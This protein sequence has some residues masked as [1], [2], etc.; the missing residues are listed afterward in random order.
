VEGH[1]AGAGNALARSF[2]APWRKARPVLLPDQVIEGAL[3]GHFESPGNLV[4]R[5]ARG[6][7]DPA[8]KAVVRSM[9]M[10][11]MNRWLPQP[12]RTA[13]RVSASEATIGAATLAVDSKLLEDVD[14]DGRCRHRDRGEA[15]AQRIRHRSRPV[16]GRQVPPCALPPR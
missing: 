15:M 16:R 10:E 9:L 12:V 5:A 6:A 7:T 1:P 8:A 11:T 4:R 3:H 13:D 14:H 2:A